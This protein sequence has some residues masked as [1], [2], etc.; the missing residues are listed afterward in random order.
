M[1]RFKAELFSSKAE[2][3]D[4]VRVS[5]CV[6]KM[7]LQIGTAVGFVVPPAVVTSD[8]FEFVGHSLSLMMYVGA[9]VTALLFIL[10][11]ICEFQQ[12]FA[13]ENS[14]GIISSLQ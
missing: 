1:F 9:G 7:S 12:I 3:Q 14:F 6:F 10:V 13:Y 8:N 11:L 2:N 4:K 5:G